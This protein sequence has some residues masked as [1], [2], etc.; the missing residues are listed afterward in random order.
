MEQCCVG[1]SSEV[2][3][4]RHTL[5][6]KFSHFDKIDEVLLFSQ[7]YSKGTPLTD[8]FIQEKAIHL[9]KMM[10][11]NPKIS[12]SNSWLDR[13]KNRDGIRQ[14]IF[15]GDSVFVNHS[16]AQEYI[17]K[18]SSVSKLLPLEIY[19]CDETGLNF[20]K[21]SNKSLATKKECRALYFKIPK[22]CV[23]MLAR[24]KAVGTHKVP[25][26]LIIK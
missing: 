19:N 21:L 4:Q 18:F 13:W 24:R 7:T 16:S 6:A 22:E 9:N 25:L 2:L 8:P 17:T 20:K 3:E 1:S 10:N 12:K 5:C 14:L 15:T 23:T 11:V 26:M